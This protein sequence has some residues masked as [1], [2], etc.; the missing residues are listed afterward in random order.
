V[1]PD[2]L[3]P[4]WP[5]CIIVEHREKE[6]K[7]FPNSFD[8]RFLRAD[9]PAADEVSKRAQD[10]L[11]VVYM[12][13]TQHN[14]PYEG[15]EFVHYG[16]LESK[17]LVRKTSNQGIA[18]EFVTDRKAAAMMLR[19]LNHFGRDIEGDVRVAHSGEEFHHVGGSWE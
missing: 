18:E 10:A 9:I 5:L 16:T 13:R 1:T 7:S 12:K 19:C 4:S 2:S 17:V 14:S 11:F 3:S 15:I 8:P 6:M